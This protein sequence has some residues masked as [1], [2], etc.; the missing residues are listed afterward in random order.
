MF[1][2]QAILLENT[3]AAMLWLEHIKIAT[4]MIIGAFIAIV[5]DLFTSKD[6]LSAK[7]LLDFL[8]DR[9]LIRDG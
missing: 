3:Q 6:T 7:D 2:E 8:K 9:D 4:I 5:K 1:Y